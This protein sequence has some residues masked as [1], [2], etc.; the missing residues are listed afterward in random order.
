MPSQPAQTSQSA[1]PSYVPSGF[2]EAFT[3]STGA[4]RIVPEHYV[5]HPVL[6]RNLSLT[7]RQRATQT[8]PADPAGGT[9]PSGDT[10][11]TTPKE[12]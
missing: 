4:K 3:V 9:S 10:T 2:V 6:G 12:K 7:P 5:E 11:R 8:P 1:Q